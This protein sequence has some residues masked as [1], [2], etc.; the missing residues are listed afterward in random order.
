M[1]HCGCK[2]KEQ[3]EMMKEKESCPKMGQCSKEMS[4]DKGTCPKK[5]MEKESSCSTGTCSK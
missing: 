3:K 2:E 4:C 1:S 5:D